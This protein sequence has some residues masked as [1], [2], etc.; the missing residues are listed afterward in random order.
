MM[1]SNLWSRTIYLQDST[2][3]VTIANI[4]IAIIMYQELTNT[5]SL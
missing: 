4:Y 3:L 1:E 5:Q 2:F